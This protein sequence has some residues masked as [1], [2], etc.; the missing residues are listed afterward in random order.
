[1]VSAHRDRGRRDRGVLQKEDRQI[2]AQ[3][4]IRNM[5]SDSDQKR[6]ECLVQAPH[7]KQR[8]NIKQF[9]ELAPRVPGFAKPVG[10]QQYAVALAPREAAVLNVASQAERQPRRWFQEPRGAVWTNQN[11]GRV[12]AAGNRH[13][14][15]AGQIQEKGGHK[16]LIAHERPQVSVHVLDRLHK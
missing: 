13:G 9:Q 4:A 8:R 3:R 5:R 14:V 6:I 1:M 15:L 12:T 11:R 7:G 10:V 16:V 2:V